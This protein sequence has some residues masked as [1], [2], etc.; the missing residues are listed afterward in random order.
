MFCNNTYLNG[1]KQHKL[2]GR[3]KLS[4]LENTEIR[5]SRPSLDHLQS[6]GAPPTGITGVQIPSGEFKD[7]SG[8]S[9]ARITG[10]VD[11]ILLL[12]WLEFYCKGSFAASFRDAPSVSHCSSQSSRYP[13]QEHDLS[14]TFVR[15]S[16]GTKFYDMAFDVFVDDQPFCTIAA[17]PRSGILHEDS[18]SVKIENSALYL[19]RF[20]L[21]DYI[22]T[23]MR[24]TRLRIC[25]ITRLDLAID[26][27]N[28]INEIS[29]EC[30]KSDIFVRSGR[31]QFRPTGYDEKSKK[32]TG[33]TIGSRASDRFFSCY[34]KTAEIRS[35]KK[36][37]I[38][39][40]HELNYLEGDVYRYEV[41]LKSKFLRTRKIAL[42]DLFDLSKMY[43]LYYS[44]I[45]DFVVFKI[46]DNN[47]KCRCTDI[48]L[49]SYPKQPKMLKT[50][51]R[52]PM[53][54]DRVMKTLA[55]SLVISLVTSDSID[56]TGQQVHVIR[57]ESRQRDS[58]MLQ[59][60]V[61][62]LEDHRLVDWFNEKRSFLVSDIMKRCIN[63]GVKWH[64]K[65]LGFEN[66]WNY[67]NTRCS[68]ESQFSDSFTS[69]PF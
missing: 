28:E 49:F 31:A 6:S 48:Q 4:L 16:Y 19:P 67:V 9:E 26:G 11:G 30:M 65:L 63:S 47:R 44:A 61:T 59:T 25:S 68:H 62:L 40:I 13:D 52:P 8:V 1:K 3:A 54:S 60:L 22:E 39:K 29:N 18:C 24:A 43:D 51:E 2:P 23:F 55:K 69:V 15:R 35:G 64:T 38:G 37:Y 7:G 17:K 32:F 53:I 14:F 41:R 46:N 58:R 45:S 21:R 36:G 12:D 27:T 56:T 20:D 42:D 57:P 34:N 10:L 66:I 50:I 33:F 5:N